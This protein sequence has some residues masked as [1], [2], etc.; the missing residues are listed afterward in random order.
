MREERGWLHS[1]PST[2]RVSPDLEAEAFLCEEGRKG[3]SRQKG[4]VQANV[5]GQRVRC[6][7]WLRADPVA[8]E[9]TAGAGGRQALVK[10]L[11]RLPGE[12]WE[13]VTC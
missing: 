13:S 8:G 9:E 4:A 10:G 2:C 7:T 3:H 6:H 5:L 1:P 12:Q 11:S